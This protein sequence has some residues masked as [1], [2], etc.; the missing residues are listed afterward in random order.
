MR[1]VVM[2]LAIGFAA[3]VGTAQ[4]AQAQPETIQWPACSGCIRLFAVLSGNNETP[5]PGVVTGANG[6]AAVTVDMVTLTVTWNI[7]VFNIPTGTNNAHFHVGG[8]G[9]AGPTVVNIP[10]TSGAT[11]DYTLTGS[12]TPANLLVR[13]DQGIRAWED[14]IQSLLAG[15]TY[16]NIH[17]TAN[18]GGE[19]RGQVVRLP[20]E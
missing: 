11:N 8:S 12:A 3:L 18:P 2:T 19:I 1:R 10:F 4:T 20:Q 17:T 13:G 15:Q 9:V 16:I 14:F 7:Q 5:A 6:T